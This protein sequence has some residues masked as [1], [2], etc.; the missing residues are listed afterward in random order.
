MKHRVADLMSPLL[1]AAVA[2][3]EGVAWHIEKTVIGPRCIAH[4]SGAQGH[5]VFRPSVG[6]HHCGPIIEAKRIA[7]RHLPGESAEA[8]VAPSSDYDTFVPRRASYMTG[9]T[10]MIAAMR[11]YVHSF[12]G[13]EID[14]PDWGAV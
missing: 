9:P 11:A 14:L 12:S 4:W 8:C 7:L 6:W 3:A 2:T 1:D 5:Q 10:V 13:D